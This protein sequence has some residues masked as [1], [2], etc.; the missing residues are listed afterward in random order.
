MTF[1]IALLALIAIDKF[2]LSKAG[3]GTAADRAS[4][5]AKRL[6]RRARRMEA[7]AT[8]PALPRQKK[9]RLSAAPIA[10]QTGPQSTVSSTPEY[11]SEEEEYQE[12][13][14]PVYSEP[15]EGFTSTEPDPQNQTDPAEFTFSD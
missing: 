8:S 15:N 5:R 10:S 2:I 6:A 11:P 7:Q 12:E 13:E 1:P 9:R 3:T 14:Y 4:K